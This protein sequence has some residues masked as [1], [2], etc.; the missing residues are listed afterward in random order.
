[1]RCRV[2]KSMAFA[3]MMQTVALMNNLGWEQRSIVIDSG[4]NLAVCSASPVAGNS[5]ALYGH[6]FL[7]GRVHLK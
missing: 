4:V 6:P 5:R 7:F 3:G 2:D 1:M